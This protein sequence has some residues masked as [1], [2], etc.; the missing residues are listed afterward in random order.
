MA[1]DKTFV[2]NESAI[3]DMLNSQ[4]VQDACLAEANKIK[5]AATQMTASAGGTYRADVRKGKERAQA[6]V[7]PE[8]NVAWR[9]TLRDNIILK[10][11]GGA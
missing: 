5:A 6:R 11:A 1:R 7:I 8:N 4:V 2:A 10:S 9:A 3:R